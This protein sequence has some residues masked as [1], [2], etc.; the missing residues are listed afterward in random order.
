MAMSEGIV[1][2]FWALVF[3]NVLAGILFPFFF[4][5]KARGAWRFVACF[6]LLV[7]L[8]ASG[9]LYLSITRDPT[10]HTLWPFEILIWFFSSWFF[11]L[12]LNALYN[13]RTKRDLK[14]D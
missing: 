12:G 10:R 8:S 9:A 5:F 6:P 7:A 13:A 3:L 4:F 1:F 11:T 14:R 2:C